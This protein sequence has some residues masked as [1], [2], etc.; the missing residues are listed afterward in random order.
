MTT[1]IAFIDFE[2]SSLDADSFPVEIGWCGVDPSHSSSEIIQP[3][4]TWVD[5]RW[6]L[7]AEKLHR[8]GR[9]KIVTEGS[10]PAIAFAHAEAALR[11][12]RI[13]SDAPSWDQHWLDELALAALGR[14]QM[15]GR[16]MTISPV[17]EL[18]GVIARRRGI[19]AAD[20]LD[21]ANQVSEAM[22]SLHRAGTDAS[23]LAS[24]TMCLHDDAYRRALL[25]N[26]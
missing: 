3:H 4:P 13:F 22:P 24:I 18:W 23:R 6:D 11:N 2:A 14:S 8:L 25:E 21:I 7:E 10:R 19:G 5:R 26:V 12:A 15:R 17:E 20:V 9:E 1:T 16:R